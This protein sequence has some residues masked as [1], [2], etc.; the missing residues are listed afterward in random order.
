MQ[1]VSV[2]P[3]E[4]ATGERCALLWDFKDHLHHSS[5]QTV[6]DPSLVKKCF[7]RR[8]NQFPQ[9]VYL[10]RYMPIL[11]VMTPRRQRESKSKRGRCNSVSLRSIL[12]SNWLKLC[13]LAFWQIAALCGRNLWC[14]RL[15]Q[16]HP[17]CFS[18]SVRPG[19]SEGRGPKA[20]KN[21]RSWAQ[22]LVSIGEKKNTWRRCSKRE[23][24]E[25]PEIP[26]H[27]ILAKVSEIAR[28]G[29]EV[30]DFVA[31]KCLWRKACV[32]LNMY[33]YIYNTCVCV[34]KWIYIYICVYV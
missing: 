28:H 31:S 32:Y 2:T 22:C 34:F 6:T 8:R 10:A 7:C 1:N 26:W 17:N 21:R 33:I 23:T 20:Q 12:Y 25:P 15:C 19:K 13:E 3:S 16:R 27:I 24:M 30:E 14:L 5:V 11:Q 9:G 18:S 29:T 4:S